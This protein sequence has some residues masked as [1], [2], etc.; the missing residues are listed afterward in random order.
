ML[1]TSSAEWIHINY[2][3]RR[4]WEVRIQIHI[5]QRKRGVNVNHTF[6][7]LTNIGINKSPLGLIISEGVKK[8]MKQNACKLKLKPKKHAAE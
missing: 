8:K 3:L 6:C 5:K 4:Q 2:E 1:E 7:S